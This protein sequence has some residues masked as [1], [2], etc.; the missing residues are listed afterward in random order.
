MNRAISEGISN[1]LRLSVCVS[2]SS[3]HQ[4]MHLSV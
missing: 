3:Q 2:S 1:R 4:L